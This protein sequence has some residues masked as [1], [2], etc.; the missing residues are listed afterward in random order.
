MFSGCNR[1]K[2]EIN[3]RKRTGTLFLIF[4]NYTTY[5]HITY[6]LKKVLRSITKYFE[7]HKNKNTNFS[8][9]M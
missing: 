1:I 5:C 2:L 9:K 6:G 7:L 4:G 8:L 3:N